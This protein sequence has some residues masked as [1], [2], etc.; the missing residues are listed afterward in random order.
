VPFRMR[1]PWRLSNFVTKLLKFISP[2]AK[3]IDP[4]NKI[5]GR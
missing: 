4:E 5:K 1:P 3:Y 2:M